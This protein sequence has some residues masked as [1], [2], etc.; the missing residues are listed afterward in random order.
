M[1]SFRQRFPSGCKC[2]S[3]RLSDTYDFRLVK[4]EGRKAVLVEEEDT[5]AR[6]QISGKKERRPKKD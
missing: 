5:E 4:S 6:K 2:Y 1:T 3:Q